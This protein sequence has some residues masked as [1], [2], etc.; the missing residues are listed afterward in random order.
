MNTNM[1][2]V[3]LKCKCVTLDSPMYCLLSLEIQSGGGNVKIFFSFQSD[4][5]LH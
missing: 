5:L 1:K 2:Q 4:F 3:F